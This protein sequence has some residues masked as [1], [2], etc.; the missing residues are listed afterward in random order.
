MVVHG[1]GIVVLG[2]IRES[3][4]GRTGISTVWWAGSIDGRL[5]FMSG[6]LT[7]WLP[8]GRRWCQPLGLL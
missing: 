7:M 3:L 8:R 1:R 6:N 4:G 2:K 5:F